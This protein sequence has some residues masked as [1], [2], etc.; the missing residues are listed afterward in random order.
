LQLG[1]N[2]TKPSLDTDPIST[3]FPTGRKQGKVI[4][5]SDYSLT[6]LVENDTAALQLFK[7]LEQ[8]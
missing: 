2:K 7:Q 6:L 8:R 4:T 3:E 5:F 1:K